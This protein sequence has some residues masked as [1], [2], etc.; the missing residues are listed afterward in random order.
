MCGDHAKQTRAAC[1]RVTAFMVGTF[2]LNVESRSD[3]ERNGE[4]AWVR[5]P[6]SAVE[7]NAARHSTHQ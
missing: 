2:I 5:K 6:L 1:G 4:G 7:S 3:I